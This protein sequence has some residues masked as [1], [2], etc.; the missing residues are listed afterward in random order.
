M[1]LQRMIYEI[2]SKLWKNK[3]INYMNYMT[4]KN[5]AYH[6]PEAATYWEPRVFLVKTFQLLLY[7]RLSF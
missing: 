7:M 2:L 1:L 5:V 3:I 4:L 6:Q